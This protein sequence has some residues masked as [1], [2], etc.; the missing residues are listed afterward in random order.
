MDKLLSSIVRYLKIENHPS[1]ISSPDD[2]LPNLY[3]LLIEL[4]KNDPDIDYAY[5]PVSYQY[6][7]E[8]N[9]ASI[10][11]E[12][13]NQL[14][15][16]QYE[17]VD[18]SDVIRGGRSVVVV[19]DDLDLVKDFEAAANATDAL[20]KKYR[21]KLLFTYIIENPLMVNRLKTEVWSYSSTQDVFIYH[22]LGENWDTALLAEVCHEQYRQTLDESKLTEISKLSGNH[23]GTFKRLYRDAVLGSE[24]AELYVDSFLSDFEPEEINTLKKLA[25]GKKLSLQEEEIRKAF[26]KVNLINEQGIINIPYI[27]ERILSFRIKDKV[28]VNEGRTQISGADL[29]LLSRTERKIVEHLMLHAEE[30]D[31]DG[32]ADI[33]WGDKANEKYS[34]WAIDQRMSRLK[35]KLRDLGFNIDV[36]TVYGKGY[37]LVK[38]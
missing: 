31:K 24:Q 38:L 32:I 26:L 4:D 28:T 6:I 35:R 3:E 14:H 27:A 36:K 11:S 10:E 19:M 17:G 30:V 16:S 22:R 13:N 21:G 37:Q 12:I 15:L 18:I 23:F 1:I 34:E 29:D 33:I 5:C 7:A 20:V 25:T 9:P 8:I 2:G